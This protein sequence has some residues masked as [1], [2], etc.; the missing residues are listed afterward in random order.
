M[1]DKDLEKLFA[2]YRDVPEDDDFVRRVMNETQYY[3]RPNFG[4]RNADWVVYIS[5]FVALIFFVLNGGLS[6][7][8]EKITEFFDYIFPVF[9]DK[10]DGLSWINYFAVAILF[11]CIS[12]GVTCAIKMEDK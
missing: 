6:L 1:K 8:Y 5:I 4:Y 12:C 9:T 3:H 2:E 7:L 10:L 11:L